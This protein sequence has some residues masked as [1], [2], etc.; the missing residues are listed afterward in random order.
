MARLEAI[1]K[2]LYYPSPLRV[3]DFIAQLVEPLP[4]DVDEPRRLLDVCAGEGDAAA[5]LA[6]AWGLEAYGVELDADR[7]A[8]AKRKL[9]VCLHGSYH[10]LVAPAAFQ[11]LFLNPPY[12][13]GEKDGVSARQEVQ[14][15]M[16]A[17]EWLQPGGL[18]VFIPPRHVLE[19]E[20]F[21]EF[22]RRQ[23]GQIAAWSFPSP[24]VDAFDQVVVLARK[25]GGYHYSY[26]DIRCFETPEELQVL[27]PECRYSLDFHLPRP[28]ALDSFKLK[29][30][31]PVDIAPSWDT[32]PTW[33]YASRQWDILVG[34]R[35]LQG[36]RPLAQ[37]RPGH[38]AMLLAAGALD[39]C[40]LTDGTILKGGSEKIKIEFEEEDA[41][42]IRERIVSRLSVLDLKTGDYETWRAD[43]DPERTAEW[44]KDHGEDLAR[45]IQTAY[46][47]SFDGD[48]TLFEKA[49][50]RL[51]APG[52]LPGR[53][54][55]EFLL[56]QK[57]AAAA[58]AFWWGKGQKSVVISGEMGTGKA[59]PLTAKVLTPSGW[60]R[61]GDIQVGDQV[62][63]P[64][65]GTAT[66][67]GVF[68]QGRKPTFKVTFCDGSSTECCDEHLWQ[69]NTPLRKWRGQAPQVLSLQEFRGKLF[70]SNGNRQYFI[71]LVS[72]VELDAKDLPLD[73]YLLGVL[74]GDGGITRASSVSTADP[75]ILA[76]IEPLLPDGV[77]IRPDTSKY[78]FALTTGRRGA[79][80]PITEALRS[81]ELFGHRSETK[82]IPSKYLYA[83]V[84][85]RVALLQ[86][87]LDTD[88]SVASSKGTCIEYSS[89]AP[90]LAEGVVALVQSL[91]GVA[92][93]SSRIPKYT[94]K[95]EVKKGLL[96]Y[97]V[98]CTLPPDVQP[99]RLPRKLAKYRPGTKYG[100]TRSFDKVEYIGEQECQCIKLDSENQ[101]YVTDD[102]IVTH[103][104]SMA[105]MATTLAKFPKVIVMCP[106]HLVPKWIRECEKITGKEGI[107][108]TARTISEVDAF[109]A[110]CG[111]SDLEDRCE[112]V[113]DTFGGTHTQSVLGRTI[114]S[115]LETLGGDSGEDDDILSMV[116]GKAHK[117]RVHPRFLILSKEM[118]K[119]GAKW[120]PAFQTRT[121]VIE[122][123]VD[124][125]E[126]RGSYNYGYGY[127]YQPVPKKKI[128]QKIEAVICPDCGEVQ[129][130]EGIPLRPSAFNLKAQRSCVACKAPM[131]QAT[132]ISAKGTKRWP[133]A[134]YIN[135]RY[136]RRY[137][138]VIDEAHQVAGA[139]SD[140]SKAAQDL[141]SGARKILAMTGTLYGGRASSIFHLLYKVDPTFRQMYAYNECDR[142]VAHHGLFEQRFEEEER[143]SVYGYRRGGAKSGGRI[144]EIPGMS[145]A[146]IP[147]LL[148][149]T[150]FI[151]LKDLR[152]ELPPYEEQVE[153]VDHDSDILDAS[154]RLQGD[155]K[156]ILRKHPEI[157]GQYLMA[158]LG[159]PD[160]PEQ[161]E[162]IVSRDRETGDE[163]VVATA[164][165]FPQRVLPKDERVVEIVKEENAQGRQ[166]LVYFSQTHRRD[167]RM[168]VKSALEAEGLRVK[169]L[170]ANVPP[171]KREE[172]LE[173][174][175]QEG[176]DVM[177]TNGR[178]VETGM[179]LL[180][181][182]TIIQYGTEYSVHS[183]RQSLRRSWR[184]GQRK[185]IKVI[186]LVYRGTMQEVAINL[187]AR[188]MR[189]AEMVDG[190]ENGGLAQF[191]ES[192]SNFF[193]ELAQEA[194]QS[195]H[196]QRFQYA[197]GLVA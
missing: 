125:Y 115:A 128:K 177:L 53:T 181:A 188:K 140:Q 132:P 129:I 137:A 31:N 93:K 99:F 196:T 169:V 184:L 121:V 131:W 72:P 143:T 156:A 95:G 105:T 193:L 1:A 37:P 142:F 141:C 158:C 66:V 67:V 17:T 92:T 80:N 152:L 75:D 171:D 103:N 27:D 175:Q 85:Q 52:I 23:Y 94:Y 155:V 123:E 150:L 159:Y 173:R 48:L 180:F 28:V 35:G 174:A 29:G 54:K 19:I 90:H 65:G 77:T 106:S 97:R 45:A 2:A 57:E 89:S 176:F 22:M 148:P 191:D 172:W 151:K 71:P 134:K 30:I 187:I 124:D 178:L 153:L 160:C 49:L 182:A 118:A 58:T 116:Q 166:V 179:D 109:F 46:T 154:T 42:V 108:V 69:V 119:L 163:E 38:Q 144:R 146:M 111:N 82:F 114:R 20:A 139:N 197:Q 161:D 189:A 50:S 4:I 185:P 21:R 186:F 18:L 98:I 7:A 73:P 70:H 147:T 15:L 12:D 136:K 164:P 9:K 86:G 190:D 10:Q 39:G 138:L 6:S 3:V 149:Y 74:L 44:F 165:A 40:E 195:V 11:V 113:L 64:E 183:L 120:M 162:T 5:R 26:G 192:G 87:L 59:Q 68:P 41:L 130:S 63:N 13:W 122:K 34:G 100:P 110:D 79:L 62:I 83:S 14:F 112:E 76:E 101:L 107:A 167:A 135:K 104:T 61:M 33:A 96:S 43:S 127:G 25:N 194:V 126:A 16:D 91:G 51:H 102:Y 78:N 36:M 8:S 133:L 47:P 145:P 168:R 117:R 32:N 60:K 84:N 170:D 81:L 24:E 88:G 157:L 56:Q 55:P